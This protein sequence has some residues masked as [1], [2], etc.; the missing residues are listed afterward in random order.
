[1]RDEQARLMVQA[2]GIGTHRRLDQVHARRTEEGGHELVARL[3]VD[4]VGQD[5]GSGAA[6]SV[7]IRSRLSVNT[8]EA[9]VDAAVAG[10][11]VTRVLA[12]QA[13]AA[14]K[15]GRLRILLEDFEGAPAPV[16]LLHAGQGLLPQKTRAFLDLATP[17]LRQLLSAPVA[18]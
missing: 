11:G 3:L 14:V 7:A 8:A 6:R 18:A 5:P 17:A 4:L 9:A 10:L 16:S 12:Y 13:A 2:G 15:A 1:M